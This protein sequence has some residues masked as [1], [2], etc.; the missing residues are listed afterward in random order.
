MESGHVKA[1]YQPSRAGS[2]QSQI[3]S[4]LIDTRKEF[5]MESEAL[6]TSENFLTIKVSQIRLQGIITLESLT[7]L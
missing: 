3:V 6:V 5:N 2:A 7:K 1:G 4:Q